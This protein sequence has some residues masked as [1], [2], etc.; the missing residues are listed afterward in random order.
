MASFDP[1]FV[2]GQV[3]LSILLDYLLDP[4]LNLVSMNVFVNI[5][6]LWYKKEIQLSKEWVLESLAAMIQSL[7]LGVNVNG[8]EIPNLICIF[9]LVSDNSLE[10]KELVQVLDLK[11]LL[12]GLDQ[13]HQVADIVSEIILVL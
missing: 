12:L 3:E 5:L 2:I 1:M 7:S 9:L 13:S 10:I 6:R 4:S 8:R 11:Q